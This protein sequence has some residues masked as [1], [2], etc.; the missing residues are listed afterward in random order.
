MKEVNRE[1]CRVEEFCYIV[2]EFRM[3]FFIDLKESRGDHMHNEFDFMIPKKESIRFSGTRSFFLRR[4]LEVL[5]SY[6][7]VTVI[8]VSTIALTGANKTIFAS[9]R[10]GNAMFGNPM[11]GNPMS[12]N[13]ISENPMSGNPMSGNPTSN[14]C[15]NNAQWSFVGDTLT[16]TGTGKMYNYSLDNLPPWY[17]YRDR[18]CSVIIQ[19]GI[20]SI[21]S[22]AFYECDKFTDIVIPVSVK[23]IEDYA[24]YRC[25]KLENVELPDMMTS[26]GNY[27]F[28]MCDS[29]KSIV[30][31]NTAPNYHI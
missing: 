31:P 28:Y 18:I 20:T 6:I 23:T 22:Y 10:S 21:G 24:F 14:Y 3:I 9:N 1:E 15:G 25:R 17:Q 7:L 19:S 11:S 26:L 27:T 30:I 16:I 29:L 4:G 8:L 12:G 2:L 5:L 13:P